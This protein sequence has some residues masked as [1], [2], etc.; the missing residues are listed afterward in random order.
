MAA[1]VGQAH[2]LLSLLANRQRLGP[3]S[4]QQAPALLTPSQD[5]VNNED[6]NL[7]EDFR[8]WKNVG[9]GVQYRGWFVCVCDGGGGRGGGASTRGCGK[10]GMRWLGVMWAGMCMCTWGP[11]GADVALVREGVAG[12]AGMTAAAK[13]GRAG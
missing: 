7:K 12:R 5:A 4:K 1:G 2:S 6:F 10:S 3:T 11:W 9:E 8:R 13:V